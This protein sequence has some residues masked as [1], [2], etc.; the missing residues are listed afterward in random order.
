V[1]DENGYALDARIDGE[2]LKVLGVLNQG[3]MG[4]APSLNIGLDLEASGDTPHQMMASANGVVIIEVSPGSIAGGLFGFIGGN[5]LFEVLGAVVPTGTE[6]PPTEEI[7]CVVALGELEDGVMKIAPAL[8][9]TPLMDIAGRGQIDFETEAL[10]LKWSMEN[11]KGLGLSIGAMTDSAFKL[12]GTLTNPRIEMSPLD[13]AFKVGL[14]GATGG[15]NLLWEN[16]RARVA[17]KSDLCAKGLKRAE[18]AR[19]AFR[20][21]QRSA[22]PY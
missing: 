13:T 20:K 17:G 7:E 21:S 18:K 14:T 12:G 19:A 10:D 22:G 5:V 8:L 6:K 9:R 3:D 16:L 2:N 4:A 15:L 1:P 11:R